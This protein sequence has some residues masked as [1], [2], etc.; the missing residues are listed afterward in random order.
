M[1]VTVEEIPL[2]VDARGWLMA[3]DK[4][5]ENVAYAYATCCL[6]GAVKAWHRHAKHTDRMFCVS[7]MARVVLV[8]TNAHADYFLET[9]K[10]SPFGGE[11]YVIGPLAPKLIT[12]PPGTW[13][14]FAALGNEPCVIINCPDMPYDP[15][16]EEKVLVNVIPF[17]WG[18][19]AW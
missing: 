7:G 3:T 18:R 16:D 15:D 11:E 10:Y 4:V 14:G 13:H 1:S 19:A 2:H 6:P 12:V 5:L 8:T 17:E 9:G